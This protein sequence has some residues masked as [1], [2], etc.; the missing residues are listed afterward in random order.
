MKE[1]T[2][3]KSDEIWKLDKVQYKDEYCYLAEDK[4]WKTDIWGFDPKGM[5]DL[6]TINFRMIILSGKRGF[7]EKSVF[8]RMMRLLEKGL[9][10]PNEMNNEHIAKNKIQF[11]WSKIMY[12]LGYHKT[13]LYRSQ[14]SMTRD[15]WI[16]FYCCA[17]YL[18]WNKIKIKDLP[19][20]PWWLY[21][22]K[23]WQ[24][25]R[26]LKGKPNCYEFLQRIG[27]KPKKDFVK[28]LDQYMYNFYIKMKHT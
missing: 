28:I 6:Q 4:P 8:L 20:P 2:N 19:Y 18:D 25:I 14:K 5:G 1:T 7:W 17:I 16:Y 11:W 21:D 26:A 23:V 13:R 9:R 24:W 22:P 12:K 15:P 10:W 27:R 3:P